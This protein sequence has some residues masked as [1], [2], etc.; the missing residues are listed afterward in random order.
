VGRG[1]GDSAAARR[2]PRSDLRTPLNVFARLSWILLVLVVLYAAMVG[3]LFLGQR[4]LI[5]LPGGSPWPPADAGVPEMRP[6]TLTTADGLALTSWW[7]PPDAGRIAIVY[8]HGNAG[9]IGHRAGKVRPYLDAGLGVLL[10]G[11]RGYGG[12]PGSPTED[13]LYADARSGLEFLA[14]Q[15][16]PSTHIVLYG[17]S[18]GTGVAVQMAIEQPVAALVLEAPFSS[19]ADVAGAHYPFVPARWLLLDRFDSAAKI[20]RIVAPVM[21][22]HGERDD[23]IPIRFAERLHAA[24]GPGATF[25]RLP[26]AGHNDLQYHGAAPAVL[27][28]LDRRLGRP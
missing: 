11:Y 23:T 13:G 20:A 5:Y 25:L 18:L 21:I 10:L 22:V 28:F 24:A 7:H 4:E 14:A 16:L 27:E 3:G 19:L 8:L 26:L 9:N 1:I 15:G 12:N 2:L 6:V 17:E